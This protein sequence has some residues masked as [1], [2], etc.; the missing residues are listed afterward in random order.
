MVIRGRVC[1][2]DTSQVSG[3]AVPI[4]PTLEIVIDGIFPPG[5]SNI[6]TNVVNSTIGVPINN[7]APLVVGFTPSMS[8]CMSLSSMKNAFY[9]GM[10]SMGIL[11][12]LIVSQ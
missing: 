3:L 9:I 4:S 12:A 10:S 8:A 11:N 2:N 5:V 6:M 7:T 1:Y